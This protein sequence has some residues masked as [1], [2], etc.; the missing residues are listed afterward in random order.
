MQPEPVACVC[1]APLWSQEHS[2]PGT[3]I[4]LVQKVI[5]SDAEALAA[6]SLSNT[7]H[8]VGSTSGLTLP[9]WGFRFCGEGQRHIVQSPRDFPRRKPNASDARLSARCWLLAQDELIWGKAAMLLATLGQRTS[10]FSPGPQG[11]RRR[12]IYIIKWLILVH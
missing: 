5:C 3:W 7:H 6:S 8:G 4:L 10:C 9:S 12:Q 11:V 1:R 2:L